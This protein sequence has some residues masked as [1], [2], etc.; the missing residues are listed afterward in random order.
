MNTRRLGNSEIELTTVGI[1]TWAIGGGDWKFGW[2]AQDEQEAVQ[3]ILRG[4]QLGIN[5]ID[6]A[7]VYGNGR[8]EEIVAKALQ[9]IPADQRPLVA[10]KFGRVIQA[11]GSIQA[12]IKADSIR[13]ECEASLRRLQTDCIDL[14]QM[15]WPQPDEDI[16]EAWTTMVQLK[17]EGKVRHIG[18]SNHSAAQMA[19]L[20]TIHPITSLQPPYSMLVRGIEDD[21]LPYCQAHSIGVV[22][23]SPMYKGLLTGKFDAQRAAALSEDDHRSRDPQF[24]SPALE[25]NLQFVESLK[26]VAADANVSVAQLAILWTLRNEVVTSAIV[27]ARSPKQIEETAA[28]GSLQLNQDVVGQLNKLLEARSA[29]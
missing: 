24:Q 1:G 21:I 27:G 5:W 11:D 6:T 17:Q 12:I 19:R 26:T 14:Y 20:Q 29:S 13:R 3:G 2:G 28:V 9:Q 4:V 22:C 23:Y 8:S 16:E 18:V 10:T 25:K 7:A 15:H